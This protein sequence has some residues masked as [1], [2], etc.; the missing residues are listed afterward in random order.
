MSEAGKEHVRKN[1]LISRQL[2]DY[3]KLF[4]ETK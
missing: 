2:L 3:L 1:F 4:N